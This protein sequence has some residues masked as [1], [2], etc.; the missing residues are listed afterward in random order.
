MEELRADFTRNCAGCEA[1]IAEPWPG[2]RMGYRCGAAGP[3]KGYMVGIGRFRP[4]IP[5]WCPKMRRN[6]NK[7]EEIV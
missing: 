1:V 4:Y 3:C 5:A 6:K 7:Q 2:G